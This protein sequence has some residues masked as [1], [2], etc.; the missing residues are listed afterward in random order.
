MNSE[1]L[2]ALRNAIDAVL[3]DNSK[4]S[5]GKRQSKKTKLKEQFAKNYAAGKWKQKK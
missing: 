1:N 4:P 2:I 3:G 5:P